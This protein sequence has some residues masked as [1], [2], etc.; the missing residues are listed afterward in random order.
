MKT[1][2]N[3]VGAFIY[4]YL[5]LLIFSI[6]L[7]FCFSKA[8]L[9]IWS[10]SHYSATGDFFFKYVTNLGDGVFVILVSVAMLFF[11]FRNSIMIFAT[12]ILAGLFVQLIKHLI[13]PGVPR[14]KVFF[15]GIYQLHF[16]EG[17]KILSTNSFPSGHS[18][19]AF[20]L[21]LCLSALTRQNWIRIAL[22]CLAVL[23]AYSRVYLS[24]H[25]LLDIVTGSF[26]G[27]TVSFLYLIF[28][29]SFYKDWMEN[30]ILSLRDKKNK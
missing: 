27:V 5:G 26:I 10:N 20:A 17:V 25:F 1:V 12:Y 18:A 13:L 15:S 7:L 30:S 24:Q 6:V 21:F 8:E 2:L 23:V 11:R 19:S 4:P 9:H 28:E 29:K 16:V 14:P 3:K 22:L